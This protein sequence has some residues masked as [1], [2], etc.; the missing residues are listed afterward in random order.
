MSELEKLCLECGLNN[1][2]AVK[3]HHKLWQDWQV[4]QSPLFQAVLENKPETPG[5]LHLLGLLTKSH[6][7]LLS[8]FTP[9]IDSIHAMKNAISN[10][11]GSEH[12][13]KF[14]TS[15]VYELSLITH[16]WLYIQGYLG[17]DFSLA[18]EHALET[19]KM[20]SSI[21]SDDAQTLRTSFLE[22]FYE[23]THHQ[24]K[25]ASGR[26]SEWIKQLFNPKAQ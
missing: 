5:K 24:P 21:N 3:Q 17:M 26:L 1:L 22:S 20:I 7:E 9:Y 2:A 4:T 15:H 11:V 13:K 25:R 18:N 14:K 8:S 19:A 6:I 10:T 12:E 16:A 23:G